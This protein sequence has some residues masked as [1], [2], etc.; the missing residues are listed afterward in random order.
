MLRGA[1][2]VKGRVSVGTGYW[3]LCSTCVRRIV[4]KHQNLE[5]DRKHSDFSKNWNDP[6][7]WFNE[8]LCWRAKCQNACATV[9]QG[10]WNRDSMKLCDG[11]SLKTKLP[12]ATQTQNTA[13]HYKVKLTK[14]PGQHIPHICPFFST[15]K[16]FAPIFLHAKAHRSRC[17]R[18]CD[19]T[20]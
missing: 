3:M 15:D 6:G 1:V 16:N 10:L 12:T 9:H 11:L 4:G 17:H 2:D 13:K 14:D 18:F 5:C 19:K 7:L 8:A 20:A